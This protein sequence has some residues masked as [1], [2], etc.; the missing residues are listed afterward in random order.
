MNAEEENHTAQPHITGSCMREGKIIY[1]NYIKHNSV[2]Y[3]L[4]LQKYFTLLIHIFGL[5]SP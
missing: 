3:K 1:V 2:L 5:F 4:L